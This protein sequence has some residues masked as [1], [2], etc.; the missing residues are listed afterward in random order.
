MKY[1]IAWT[2][3]VNGSAIENEQTIQ[4]N[5]KLFTQWPP[6]AEITF[7][8]FV[9]RADGGGGFAVVETDNAPSMSDMTAKF[10][11]YHEFA[12]YPVVEIDEAE[13]AF[14]QS[15]EFRASIV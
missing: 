9:N 12:I 14:Q 13:Q 11:P 10:V 15:V 7:L 2:P 3:R 8:Q 5:L 6:P 1:V 4:R